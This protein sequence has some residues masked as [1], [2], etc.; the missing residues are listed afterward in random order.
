LFPLFW[1]RHNW[2]DC[3]TTHRIAVSSAHASQSRLGRA[4]ALHNLG[5]GLLKLRDAE[6]FDCLQEASALRQEAG[7]TDGE[8]RTA[9]GLVEAHYRINGPQAAYDNSLQC[10]ELLRKAG[11]P[12]L[13]GG[14]LN[15]HG[16]FCLALSKADEATEC[17]QE[18]LGLIT[19]VGGG[20][21]RGN[22]LENLGRIHLESGRFP[23]AIASLS[24]AHRLQQAEG[25]LLG[26][27]DALKYLGKAQRADG[28]ADQAGKSLSP[29]AALVHGVQQSWFRLHRRGLR[30]GRD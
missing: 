28:R 20:S 2:A 13:L 7:N 12:A 11:D 15:N 22:V 27:A 9:V 26:Q 17:L 6:A 30:G 16:E 8:A 23:E 3:V 1:R 4:W 25:D 18:A 29:M 21:G 14:A 5:Y 24:E 10:L 19:A